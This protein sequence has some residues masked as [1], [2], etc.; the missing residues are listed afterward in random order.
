MQKRHSAVGPTIVI[1]RMDDPADR[2]DHFLDERRHL[3]VSKKEEEQKL[4][5][6]IITLGSGALA[7]VSSIIFA[8]GK[9][10]SDLR[11]MELAIS[12]LILIFFSILLGVLER[13][14][15]SMAYEERLERLYK[16]YFQDLSFESKYPQ[17]IKEVYI[18]SIITFV[19]GS[20]LT[21]IALLAGQAKAGG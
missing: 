20:G 15:S 13:F 9:S 8:Q 2:Y 19:F 4:V 12:G 6:S 1:E 16:E 7:L 10:I 17:R 11:F 21:A 14:L 5:D 18:Y 3:I